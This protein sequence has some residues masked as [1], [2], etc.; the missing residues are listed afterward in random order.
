VRNLEFTVENRG[1]ARLKEDWR[2]RLNNTYSVRIFS[3]ESGYCLLKWGRFPCD[4]WPG[5]SSGTEPYTMLD[6]PAA[7]P[8]T[9]NQS[10]PRDSAV[11]EFTNGD[12]PE[13]RL[14]KP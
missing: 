2:K 1:G 7:L 9:E 5:Q 13:V 12:Q 10:L 11:V 8:T 6:P 4:P 14:R 3:S